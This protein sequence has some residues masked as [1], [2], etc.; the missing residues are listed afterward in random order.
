MVVGG[1]FRVEDG[2]RIFAPYFLLFGGLVFR[3]D[4]LLRLGFEGPKR[5]T[6]MLPN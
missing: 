1:K 4:R 3:C 2:G 6:S 5:L